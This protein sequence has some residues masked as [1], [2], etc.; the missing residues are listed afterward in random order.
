MFKT[1]LEIVLV[2]GGGGFLKKPKE[3]ALC[4]EL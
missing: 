3:K 4:Y 2:S 1:N